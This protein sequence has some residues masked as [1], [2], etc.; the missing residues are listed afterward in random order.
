M[1]QPPLPK[2]TCALAV[3]LDSV[4]STHKAAHNYL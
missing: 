3:D 1:A 4:L 2:S